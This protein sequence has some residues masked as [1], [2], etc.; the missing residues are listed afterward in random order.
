[1]SGDYA[2]FAQLDL[3]EKFPGAQAMFMQLCG[4]DQNALPRGEIIQTQTYGAQLATAVV[5]AMSG[6]M[7]PLSGPLRAAYET[8]PLELQ[9]HTREEFEGRIGQEDAR[10]PWYE[11]HAKMMLKHYDADAPIREIEY[12]VQAIALGDA[13]TMLV[14]SG[15]VVVDY[16]LRAKRELG[17]ENLIVAGYS[18]GIVAY[19]PSLRVLREGGYEGGDSMI[20]FGL[21]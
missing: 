3:E 13:C 6:P 12:P 19:L 5:R 7:Q 15:E 10:N 17:I 21:P 9:P 2:G 18:N 8:I 14:L 20:Y 11:R 16:S 4:A 1:I